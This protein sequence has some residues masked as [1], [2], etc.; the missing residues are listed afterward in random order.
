MTALEEVKEIEIRQL[1]FDTAVVYGYLG[2]KKLIEI[3]R[4]L[5]SCKNLFSEKE[6]IIF[7]SLVDK[8]DKGE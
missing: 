6:R 3:L 2:R 1:I 4:D 5:I 8:M 7:K